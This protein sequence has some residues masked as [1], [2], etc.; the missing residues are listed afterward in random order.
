MKTPKPAKSKPPAQPMRKGVSTKPVTPVKSPSL[1]TKSTPPPKQ[2]T[3][4]VPK[5]KT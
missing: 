4:K 2:R 1:P 3:K 5:K